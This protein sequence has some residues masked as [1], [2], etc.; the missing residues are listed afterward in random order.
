[1]KNIYIDESGSMTTKYSNNNRFFV[2]GMIIV[3][4]K[5]SSKL[6]NDM[7]R[8]ISNNLDELRALDVNQKMFFPDGKFKEL[9]GSELSPKMKLDF[10]RYMANN[11]SFKIVLIRIDNTRLGSSSLYDNTARAFNY[12]LTLN[13]KHNFKQGILP[14]EDY[15]LQIDQRNTRTES[16]NALEEHLWLYLVFDLEYMK[17]VKVSYF[18]SQ[19]SYLVQLAD[20]YS[21]LYFSYLHNPA[22]YKKIIWDLIKEKTIVDEFVFPPNY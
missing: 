11:K 17:S 20:F 15:S 2:I 10:A 4:S 19:D 12:I 13:L 8:Y 21:N 9:K 3:D 5:K 1:M 18:E 16:T 7:K 14:L 22:R 6:K